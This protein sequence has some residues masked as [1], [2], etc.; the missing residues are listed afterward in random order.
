MALAKGLRHINMSTK[1]FQSTTS[2]FLTY[3]IF[4]A[5]PIVALVYYFSCWEYAFLSAIVLFV[6]IITYSD[7][8][9]HNFRLEEERFVVLPSLFFWKKEFGIAY[10]EIKSIRIKYA[11]EKD[12]RQWLE[13]E[14]LGK[15]NYRYRCDWLHTQDPPDEED[16]HELPEGEL[17]EILKDEDFYKGSLNELEDMLR[18]KGVLVV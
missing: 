7:R 5:A 1:T 3:L 11:Q 4:K 8:T 13:I 10:K 2:V 17:F 6:A 9:N 15:Q 18:T 16:D 14:A 12:S